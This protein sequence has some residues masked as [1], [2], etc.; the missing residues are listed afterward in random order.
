MPS[1]I[2]GKLSILTIKDLIE[3]G[4]SAQPHIASMAKMGAACV[5]SSGSGLRHG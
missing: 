1:G 4:E 5:A 2:M 3:K